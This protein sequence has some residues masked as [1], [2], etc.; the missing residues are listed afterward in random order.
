MTIWMVA[1]GRPTIVEL[2]AQIGYT[3]L[4]TTD[5]NELATWF[6]ESA[7]SGSLERYLSTFEHTVAVMQHTD[8]IYRVAR[9]CA[10]DLADRRCGLRGEPVGARTERGGRSH[11]RGGRGGGAG[12]IPL[13]ANGPQPSG[14]SGFGWARC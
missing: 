3:G 6:R 14:A 2:A 11:A 9:E 12:R 10:E 13:T 8:G 7:G 4:P 1:C 5:P